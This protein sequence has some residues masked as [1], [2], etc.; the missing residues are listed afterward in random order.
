MLPQY[1]AKRISARTEMCD[2]PEQ[3]RDAGDDCFYVCDKSFR[4]I[5]QTSNFG[6]L[7]AGNRFYVR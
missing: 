3:H 7:G 6:A 1:T 5:F 4:L 2:Y